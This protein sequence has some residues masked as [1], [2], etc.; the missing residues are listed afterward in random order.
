MKFGAS[1]WPFRWDPPYDEAIPRIARLGYKALELIAWTP[2]DL[3]SYYTPTKVKELRNIIKNEGVELSGFVSS[4]H[5]MASPN[6]NEREKAIEYFKR[7]VEVG[8]ELG[9]GIVNTVGDQPFAYE[10]PILT[11]LPLVQKFQMEI[12]SGLDWD[13]N[14][15]DY[16]DV[17]H[18]CGEIC[19]AA[20]MRYA[21]EPHPYC[22]VANAAG[23]L[24]LMDQVG[25]ASVGVNLDV[26][27]F[28]PVGDIPHVAIYQLGKHIFH[29]H[30]SDNDGA[31][32]VHWRPGGGKIDWD[33]AL[34]ALKDV[35]F[36]G[37]VSVE[38]EDGPGVSRGVRP[39]HG[40]YKG[41]PT[42]TAAF[43]QENLIA[44]RY[45]KECCERVGIAI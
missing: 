44:L 2:E 1:V 38:I 22:W 4:S 15:K 13:R 39:A 34:R 45:L 26:S 28:F 8:K 10:F 6:Q 20:G 12:P 33:A 11:I 31:T 32:N 29:L 27:H 9:T 40:V 21:I 24:R 30:I 37:V 3:A 25:C 19:E 17:V 35:G 36:D 43:D 41:T 5:G 18:R 16:V 42:A 7:H 14:W 23:V